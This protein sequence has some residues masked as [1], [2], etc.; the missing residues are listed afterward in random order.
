M[1]TY[2]HHRRRGFTLVELLVVI[3]IIVALAGLTAPQL[4][5]FLKYRDRMVATNNAK[6]LFFGL[7][8]FSEQYGSLP[9]RET[10]T[11]VIERT[12]TTLKLDGDS[13]NDYFRQLIAAGIFKSEDPCYAL[14]AGSKRK[15]D[16]ILDGSDALKP[17]EVGFSY[18]L[19]GTSAMPT[20]NPTRIIAVTPVADARKGLFDPGPLGDKAIVLT[21]DGG[22]H[23]FDIQP[24][25]QK[26]YLAKG[27]TLLDTGDGT[28]WGPAIHPVIKAPQTK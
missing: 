21:C 8:E 2:Q 17:G 15:P 28:R 26:L 24:G 10:A 18:L 27:K 13:S 23:Q 7:S 4:A 14:T 11:E 9:D 12:N 3:T 6:Q 19:N 5:K 20:D 25:T 22:V 1:K 16:N